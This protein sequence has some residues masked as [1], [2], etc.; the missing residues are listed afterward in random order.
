[1]SQKRINSILAVGVAACMIV[2]PLA[3][4]GTG[5][6]GGAASKTISVAWWGNQSRNDKQGQVNKLFASQNDVTVNGVFSEPSDYWSK[7][8]TAAAGRTMSD[9]IAMDSSYLTQYIDNGQLVPLDEYIENG[10]I[11]VSNVSKAVVDASRGADGKLYALTNAVN[12]PS[13]FYNKTLLDSLGITVNDDWTLD[14]FMDIARTVYEKT[15]VKTDYGYYE[16]SQPIEYV[17]RGEGKQLFKDGK[18]AATANDLV[19]YY[20]VF[21]TGIEEG[22]QLPAELFTEIN[23]KAVEQDPMVS[24]SSPERQSWCAF[25][26]SNNMYAFQNLSPNGDEIGIAPWPSPDVTKS[27]YIHPSQYWVITKNSKNPE[28]AAKWINFYTNNEEAAKI[29]LTDRGL[30]ISSKMV[31]AIS[32]ELSDAD[33]KVAA[34]IEN[35]VEPNS[36]PISMPMPAKASELNSRVAPQL[37][38]NILYGKMTAEQAAAE[39]VREANEIL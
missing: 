13:M 23:Y 20:K 36:S 28:L 11:D 16:D 15:G 19:P 18:L 26:W 29:M 38:E 7:T 27:N 5:N 33:K 32:P 21:Q 30:P 3:A 39:Y 2:M 17:V 12:A 1:M 35:V 10:T 22:W 9:V 34:Y 4:C 8:A 37:G 14:E 25:G 24:Y 6:A 31:E